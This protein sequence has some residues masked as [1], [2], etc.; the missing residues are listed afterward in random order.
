MKV[1][2]RKLKMKGKKKKDNEGNEMTYIENK[3]IC[4]EDIACSMHIFNSNKC[5]CVF[6]HYFACTR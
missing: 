2:T 3:I 5:V 6:F 4:N 1:L